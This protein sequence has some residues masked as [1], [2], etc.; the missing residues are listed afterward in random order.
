MS[1]PETKFMGS[2]RA[3]LPFIAECTR[4]LRFR[5]VLDAFSGSA[6]VSYA[7]K[8]MGG[9]VHTNDLLHFS[10]HTARATIENSGTQLG[11]RDLRRLLRRNT[12]SQTFIQDTFHDLYFSSDDDAFLDNLRANIEEIDSPLKKSLALA[13]ACRAAMKKRP[14]GIFTFTGRKGWDGRRDL[15][16]SMREQFLQAAESLNRAV[17]SNGRRNKAFRSDVF[18]IESQNYDLVYIDTPYVSPYSDCDYTRRYHFLEGLCTYWNGMELMSDT[19]T[20]KIRSYPTDFST[21]DKAAG[22]F[23]RLFERFKESILVVSYSSNAIPSKPQMIKLL[24]EFKRKVQVHEVKHRYSHGNHNHK[25]RDNKNS[26]YEYLFI[27]Q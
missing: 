14:R 4:G 13:A 12:R 6:C 15:K 23:L 22:A 16:L 9:T 19:L 17:F 11:E 8:Q 7:F 25:V 20:K 27:A 24:K 21:R 3:I 1:F 26:V 10:F 2:K 5:T 18:E